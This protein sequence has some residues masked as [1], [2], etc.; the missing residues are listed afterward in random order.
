MLKPSVATL[1]L[2]LACSPPPP[3]SQPL[4]LGR[5]PAPGGVRLLLLTEPGARI[6]AEYVPTLTLKDGT[7]VRFDTTALSPDSAYFAAPPA[8]ALPRPASQAHGL[9]KAS[10]CHRNE[11]VCRLVKLEV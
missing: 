10:V 8:A 3:A 11:A 1:G 9:L 2:L 7:V 6:S 4:W 5:E